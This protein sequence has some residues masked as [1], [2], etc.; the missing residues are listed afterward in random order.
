MTEWYDVAAA[1]LVL[2]AGILSVAAGI[3]L[4][5]FPDAMTRMHAV[6]KPQIFGLLLIIAAVAIDQR[7]FMTLFALIPAFVFQSLNAPVS[8]HMVARA[9][10]R[11]GQVDEET[12][13]IDELGPAIDRSDNELT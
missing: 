12:L 4:L 9:A 5:R 11:A 1:V 6:T 3:G 13:V 2:L 7:S 8:A 10:Y